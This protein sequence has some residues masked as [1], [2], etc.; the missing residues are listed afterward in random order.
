MCSTVLVIVLC[1]NTATTADAGVLA[2]LDPP[3]HFC[4]RIRTSGPNPLANV[5]PGGPY[6][7]DFDPPV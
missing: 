3:V 2:D 5:D 7:L 4:W 6:L 1:E